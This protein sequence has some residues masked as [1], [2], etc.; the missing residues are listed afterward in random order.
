MISVIVPLTTDEDGQIELLASAL[1]SDSHDV[2]VVFVFSG[3]TAPSVQTTQSNVT[4]CWVE[5]RG[6]GVALDTGVQNARGDV[7][8]FLHSDTTLPVEGLQMISAALD[9]P[10]TTGGWFR[11]RLDDPRWRYRLVDLGANTFSRI[12]HIATGDQAI[13]C[14]RSAYLAVGGFAAYPL[15]EDMT[16]CR[17]L[18][19]LGRFSQI[20]SSVLV[21]PRRFYERGI[22][23]TVSMNLL[24]T[25]RYFC[26]HDPSDLFQRY[27]GTPSS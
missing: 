27:Y 22:L 9:D 5:Q 2:E 11:R 17:R 7:L 25:L 20:A 26:G 19:G 12:C 1:P 13:F 16:L 10:R 8:L 24:L 14:R 3:P 4:T 15:F 6:R 18:K 23:R 21:S